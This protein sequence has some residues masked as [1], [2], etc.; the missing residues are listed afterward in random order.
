[1]HLVL[2]LALVLVP[3]WS[4][5]S[6]PPSRMYWDALWHAWCQSL[7]VFAL[8]CTVIASI[9]SMKRCSSQRCSLR[10]WTW[11][12]FSGS[13]AHVRKMSFISSIVSSLSG[14]TVYSLPSSSCTGWSSHWQLSPSTTML[15]FP[16]TC[17]TSMIW[18]ASISSCQHA[19]T[20]L[21]FLLSRVSFNT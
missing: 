13:R 1:M 5:Q 9:T 21:G 14:S 8:S 17:H 7:T 10:T 4:F 2:V 15:I 6:F 11:A 19:H 18:W 3:P 20:A 16:G 12:C